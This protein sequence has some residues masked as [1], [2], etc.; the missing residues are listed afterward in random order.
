M[1]I[2]GHLYSGQTRV[3]THTAPIYVQYSTVMPSE[4]TP[5]SGENQLK[6]ESPEIKYVDRVVEKIV[7][8]IVVKEV[9]VYNI[10]GDG[11]LFRAWYW[12]G[13]KM[14]WVTDGR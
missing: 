12:I 4:W 1:D 10:R 14:R 7:E 13:H 6:P 11:L 5:R 3:G 8:K 9:P 2:N